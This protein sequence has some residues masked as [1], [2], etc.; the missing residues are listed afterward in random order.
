MII[1]GMQMMR[2]PFDRKPRPDGTKPR[3]ERRVHGIGGLDDSQ[4]DN[5]ASKQ[6]SKQPQMEGSFMGMFQVADNPFA[7]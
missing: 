4:V 5:Q 1:H 7:K 6:A 2:V 3:K